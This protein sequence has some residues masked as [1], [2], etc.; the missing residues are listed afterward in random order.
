MDGLEK[1][2]SYHNVEIREAALTDEVEAKFKEWKET[3]HR[4]IVLFSSHRWRF[5][6]GLMDLQLN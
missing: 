5:V 4:G 1:T 6:C 3:P 2:K